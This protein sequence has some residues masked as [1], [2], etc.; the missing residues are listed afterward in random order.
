MVTSNQNAVLVVHPLEVLND[1]ISFLLESEFDF[2]VTTCNSLSEA[3]LAISKNEFCALIVATHHSDGEGFHF[4]KELIDENKIIPF[5]LLENSNNPPPTVYKNVMVKS[6]VHENKLLEE[7]KEALKV[8]FPSQTPAKVQEWTKVPL[9]PLTLFEGLPEDIFIQ[10]KT[11]RMLRLFRQ[12]DNL[13]HTDVDRYLGKGVDNFH[14][15][16]HAFL[17]LLRQIDTV[18]PTIKSNPSALIKVESSQ[19]SMVYDEECPKFDGPLAMHEE[20]IKELHETSKE[21]IAQIKKNKDL[22][23]LLKALDIDRTPDAFFRN[24]IDLICNIS[25]AVAQELSWSSET[26]YEKLIYV[27]HVHDLTLVTH[28]HLARLQTVAQ[29][30]ATPGITAEEKNLF[31]NHPKMMADLIA[32]DPR[33][34]SEAAGIVL[35]HHERSSGMGFPAGMQ[36]ARIMPTAA[37]LQ[38][39][40]DFAQYIVENPKWSFD[41]YVSRCASPFKGVPFNKIFKALEKLCKGKV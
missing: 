3:R 36:S 15:R 19:D 2:I 35:Q 23:K 9:L 11:G 38:I 25:C 12:G 6:F 5:I 34:P 22:A 16:R 32:R 41:D 18:M 7:L 27:A 24:R 14:L 21:I 29:L 20:F 8:L 30:E 26:M 13:S 31:M 39:A 10:L 4:F 1:L 33:A 37:L 40:I 28:P 17:W